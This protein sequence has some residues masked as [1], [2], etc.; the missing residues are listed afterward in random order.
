[1]EKWNK[2]DA[3]LGLEAEGWQ[4]VN[5]SKTRPRLVEGA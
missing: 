5:K 1:M 4:E 3:E 2:E